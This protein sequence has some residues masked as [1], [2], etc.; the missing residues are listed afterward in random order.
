LP[1]RRTLKHATDTS[2]ERGYRHRQSDASDTS[3][4]LGNRRQR[5]RQS[6]NQILQSFGRSTLPQLG[7]ID[8]IHGPAA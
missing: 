3:L 7:P 1:L 4:L 8:N 2:P 5:S 6:S